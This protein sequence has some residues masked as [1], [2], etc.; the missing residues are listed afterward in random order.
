MGEVSPKGKSILEKNPDMQLL[1]GNN[2]FSSPKHTGHSKEKDS[3]NELGQK[4][5]AE[6]KLFFILL[7]EFQFGN[8]SGHLSSE[9][10]MS[11]GAFVGQNVERSDQVIIPDKMKL[12]L[13]C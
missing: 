9:G 12:F 5:R 6:S 11:T 2:T 7:N 4:S 1:L 3:I 10:G 8:P 13:L